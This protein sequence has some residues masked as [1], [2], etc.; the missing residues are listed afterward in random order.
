MNTIRSAV[1]LGVGTLLLF[2]FAYPLLTFGIGRIA[3]DTADGLPLY[4]GDTLIGYQ[5]IGQPFRSPGYFHG[6]PSAV[7]YNAAATGGSNY[8]PTNPEFLAEVRSRIDTLLAHNPG[9]KRD[10]I[11]VELVTASG[12]GLD[13]HI[14][15]EGAAVQI[16]RIAAARGIPQEELRKL[17]ATHVEG[18]LLGMFGPGN[19][20]N[21]LMLNLALDTFQTDSLQSFNN[22]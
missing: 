15:A 1:V 19:R 22:E 10:K 21:V 6:R 4:R 16:P 9:L 12:G 8:G 17:V 7:G 3:S 14:T 11:P 20:V 18:P 13:P 5:N 2:G